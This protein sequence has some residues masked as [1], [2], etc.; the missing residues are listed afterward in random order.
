MLKH[1]NIVVVFILLLAGLILVDRAYSVHWS[2]YLLLF[3]AF[4]V[5]E[6]YGAYFIHSGFHLK[7]ICEI[8]T[9]DK[10]IA[11]TF[12]DGPALQTEKILTV[13]DEFNAKATFFCIGNRINGKEEILKKIDAKGHL[14]GNHSYTHSYFIDFKNTQSLVNELQ[15]A[16][17]EIQK[18]IGKTPA[19]FRPPYGVTTP[20]LA[21]AAKK[22]NFNVIGWNIRS[23][24][25]SI[26]DRQKVLSR[27]KKRLQPGSI[28]L[29]HDTIAGTELVLK[30]VFLYLKEQNYKIIALD[31]LIHE[32][33][34]V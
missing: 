22:L 6:F 33:A 17:S 7:A 25:T 13:L 9:P 18:V 5:I 21:R 2:F 30:E 12:D 27:I 34:Y 1:R 8:D 24:D 23:L 32:K 3:M 10:V 11:L 19:F 26:K 16:N 15:R 14:I 29:M 4:S 31:Q 20:A 28:L